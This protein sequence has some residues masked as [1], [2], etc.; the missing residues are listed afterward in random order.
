MT[1]ANQHFEELTARLGPTFEERARAHDRDGHFVAD[2]YSLLRENKFFS[3][4]VPADLGG[5]GLTHRELGDLIRRLAGYCGSTA[6]AYSMHSHLVAAAVW[7]HRHGQPAEALLRK[8]AQSELVL[9]STGAG[10]WV[11]SVGR[12]ERVTGGYRVSGLKRFCSSAP[13]GDLMITSAP[14][15][16][17]A[18]DEVLHFPVSLRADGVRI[19]DDWDTL[20]MR[21]TGSHS[22]ELDNVF[23]AEEAVALRRPRGR[24]HRSWDVIMT[25]AIPIYM[26]PYLGIA[27]RAAE[28]ARQALAARGADDG[29]L[30]TLGE[31]YNDLTVAQLAWR[32]AFDIANDYDVEPT[33]EHASRMLARKTLI[34]NAARATVEKA[35]EIAG[36]SAFFRAHPLERIWRD[37]QGAPFHPL[38]EKKQLTFSARVA[39]GLPPIAPG[40]PG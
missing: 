5:G 4:A 29:Q 18:G 31:L 20:G 19:R 13:M 40:T 36:G 21:A 33:P 22:I 17:P 15:A 26:A 10:D 1:A 12:A 25:V 8:V 9:V 28:H 6:L 37:I 24:W 23:I 11:D 14:L 2:N 35:I 32:D 3:A 39:L 16:D 38:P 7:R 30:L 27:E 34:A